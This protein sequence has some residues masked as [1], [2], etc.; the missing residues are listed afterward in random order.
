[1][2]S[3]GSASIRA[4][5]DGQ[6]LPAFI[7]GHA[8]PL[9]PRVRFLHRA[10]SKGRGEYPH[11]VLFPGEEHRLLKPG[12]GGTHP[13]VVSGGVPLEHL[14]VVLQEDLARGGHHLAAEAFLAVE[15]PE[16]PEDAVDLP[17]GESR[18]S[19][20]PELALDVVRGV[21]E[22]A[23]RRPSVTP[24]RDPLPAGSSRETP[25]CRH[26]S[27]AA[28]L[29]CQCPCRRRWWPRSPGARRQ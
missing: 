1:M 10:H 8:L 21:Q 27:R 4:L 6:Q 14:L 25:G 23:A 18:A 22:H 19:R 17:P 24:R 20:H 11:L 28:R 29:A 3:S 9:E 16:G 13:G 26:G 7:G 5:G 2:P 15:V 12:D